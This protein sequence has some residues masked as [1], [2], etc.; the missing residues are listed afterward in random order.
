MVA[1][2]DREVLLG[3]NGRAGKAGY[4]PAVCCGRPGSIEGGHRLRVGQTELY[5]PSDLPPRPWGW[6]ERAERASSHVVAF[7]GRWR[8]R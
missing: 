5:T 4:P 7:T 8:R 2:G 3:A 6:R 1:S